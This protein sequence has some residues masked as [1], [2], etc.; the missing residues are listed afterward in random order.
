MSVILDLSGKT[1]LV[2]GASQGI[3]AA[4]A[5][6]LHQA[7][8]RVAINQPGDLD[9]Q[10]ARDAL[11]LATELNSERPES[12]RV[13]TADVRDGS[14]VQPMMGEIASAW[15]QID[16]LVNNAGVIRD[17][18]IAKMT[19]E[20]WRTVIDVNLSGTFHC[21]KFGLEILRDGGSIVCVSSIAGRIGFH[22]QSNYA[23]SKAGVSALVR[24]IARECSGR[25][26]R[27]NAVAPGV[28]DTSMMASVK[29]GAR[30]ELIRH[31]AL[32]R[33]GRPEDVAG[34]V[35]FLCSPLAAYITGEVLEVHGGFL[36]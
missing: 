15:G 36:G 28:I 1:A 26:I 34:A 14:A 19:L 24:V 35:L 32:G 11:A 20:E 3:G 17:R 23:A 7:G 21:C 22:G 16:I 30:N 6:L 13:A 31:V 8:A 9:S 5:R 12:A 10:P 29:E 4:I 18:S 25:L 2:T 27:V 33:L